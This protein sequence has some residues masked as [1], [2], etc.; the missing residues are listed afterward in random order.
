MEKSDSLLKWKCLFHFG[1]VLKN[2]IIYEPVDKMNENK[3]LTRGIM[4]V[5]QDGKIVYVQYVKDINQ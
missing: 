5:G 4:V 2:N 3:L 1:R